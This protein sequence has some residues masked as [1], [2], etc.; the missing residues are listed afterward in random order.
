[1]AGIKLEHIHKRYENAED[2]AV[3][4][5]N[6]DVKDNEFIV[7]VGPSGCGKSTKL[8][9]I[10][11]IEEITEGDL[12]IDADVVN[13]VAPKERDIARVFQNYELYQQMTVC[14]NITFV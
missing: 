10:A 1:M 8:R 14:D 12:Y 4:D 3:T 7:F 9:L 6:L 2:F 13:D 5:F 11:G